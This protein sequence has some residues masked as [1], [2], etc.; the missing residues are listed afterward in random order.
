MR[1]KD[2]LQIIP[3]H[4]TS[5]KYLNKA[6]TNTPGPVDGSSDGGAQMCEEY[7]KEFLDRY[8]PII[9]I[10]NK[11]R[12]K[13]KVVDG[14]HFAYDKEEALLHWI[15][16]DGEEKEALGKAC[17]WRSADSQGLSYDN[18]K[19]SPEYWCDMYNQEIEEETAYALD[20]IKSEFGYDTEY[21]KPEEHVRKV[22]GRNG[23]LK[24]F[25]PQDLMDKVATKGIS[26]NT[27]R[28][29]NNIRYYISI[30]YEDWFGEPG[31]N[32]P[33]ELYYVDIVSEDE[34]KHQERLTTYNEW[35]NLKAPEVV[36]KLN[37]WK[38]SIIGKDESLKEDFNKLPNKLKTRMAQRWW[39]NVCDTYHL[40]SIDAQVFYLK[41]FGLSKEEIKEVIH[42]API[43][44]ID[45]VLNNNSDEKTTWTSDELRSWIDKEYNESLDESVNKNSF[46]IKPF[47]YT[48]DVDGE[49][50]DHKCAVIVIPDAWRFSDG[51]TMDATIYAED[52]NG[53]VLDFNNESEAQEWIDKYGDNVKIEVMH[54]NETH[55]IPRSSKVFH[56]SSERVW[57][58]PKDSKYY[59]SYWDGDTFSYEVFDTEEEMN[60]EKERLAKI[61]KEYE[62][63]MNDYRKSLEEDIDNNYIFNITKQLDIDL[64]DNGGYKYTF[65]DKLNNISF[66]LYKY[67]GY[68]STSKDYLDIKCDDKSIKNNFINL[69]NDDYEASNFNEVKSDIKSCLPK[70]SVIKFNKPESIPAP[71][72]F[73]RSG[74]G[75][76]NPRY[77]EWKSRHKESLEE[78][79]WTKYGLVR[80]NSDGT[81][82]IDFS[83]Y[84]KYSDFLYDAKDNK[85]IEILNFGD[86]RDDG[87]GPVKYRYKN[88]KSNLE[89]GQQPIYNTT[90]SYAKSKYD[91]TPEEAEEIRLRNQKIFDKQDKETLNRVKNIRR[92]IN[93][94]ERKL[95]YAAKDVI[96]SYIKFAKEGGH[97]ASNYNEFRIWCSDD[98]VREPKKWYNYYLAGLKEDMADEVKSFKNWPVSFVLRGDDEFD[99]LHHTRLDINNLADAR[100]QLKDLYGD[101]FIDVQI[102]R[103]LK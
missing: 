46:V 44:L 67:P 35:S 27:D 34:N 33:D 80:E 15:I 76:E 36:S 9:D 75:Y 42:W 2:K 99:D 81:Y 98:G 40:D 5:F 102:D 20:D 16:Q 21:V 70:G 24:D 91:T 79:Y 28:D 56:E 51:S 52:E 89:E 41:G 90:I 6:L 26:M 73:S 57:E 78:D 77:T 43:E 10:N 63:N 47:S 13:T 87:W 101:D 86:D 58:L 7:D 17:P 38:Q 29:Y 11:A 12:F 96:D 30:H 19:E 100:K 23:S 64:P 48:L 66:S 92:S 60:K 4:E 53:N 1:K 93:K 82:Q 49:R 83:D 65:S 103:P 85:N 68:W 3:D 32:N 25:D 62:D 59:L 94:K 50:S 61:N 88:T 72:L 31:I 54:G 18:W 14:R 71:W 22:V 84:D 55:A 69:F 97:K 8:N 37:A 74:Y 45:R 95:T 39:N